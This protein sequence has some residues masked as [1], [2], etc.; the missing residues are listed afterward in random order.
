MTP[1][2][3]APSWLV[4]PD[5]DRIA[6]VASGYTAQRVLTSAERDL[7][8]PAIRF[9]AA[10]LG[11]IHFEQALLDGVRGPSMDARLARLRN[12]LDVSAAVARLAAPWLAGP[13]P[14]R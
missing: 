1:G 7:L 5:P 4:R 9:A 14:V 11:A 6:A 12:R 10:Y 3:V 2:T 13:E 8:L